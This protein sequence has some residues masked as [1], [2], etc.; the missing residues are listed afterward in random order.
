[1]H[2]CYR[3]AHDEIVDLIDAYDGIFVHE[4]NNSGLSKVGLVRFCV[5]S[6]EKS[7]SSSRPI[8]L[9]II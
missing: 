7:L 1:M 8:N 9:V 5:F 4:D 2:S 6:S 3:I